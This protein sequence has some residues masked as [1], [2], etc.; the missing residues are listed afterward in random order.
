MGKKILYIGD[1]KWCYTE[2]CAVH[3]AGARSITP[4]SEKESALLREQSIKTIK[5]L[6]SKKELVDSGDTEKIQSYQQA[7]LHYED[8]RL[9]LAISARGRKEMIERLKG[10]S[11]SKQDKEKLIP[12]YEDSEQLYKA[13]TRTRSRYFYGAI[14]ASKDTQSEVQAIPL[15]IDNISQVNEWVDSF[16]STD[17]AWNQSDS[18]ESLDNVEEVTATDDEPVMDKKTKTKVFRKKNKLWYRNHEG[19]D[20]ELKANSYL[21]RTKGKE[22]FDLVEASQFESGYDSLMEKNA[23]PLQL[24]DM[25]RERFF[26]SKKLSDFTVIN[27]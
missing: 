2:G 25:G 5:S 12:F 27:G 3:T 1:G 18:L 22:G 14:Y 8:A 15:S 21:V 11:I 16:Y 26:P 10:N 17:P 13:Y 6:P 7:V 24:H 19:V 4:R 20:S 23:E 9:H